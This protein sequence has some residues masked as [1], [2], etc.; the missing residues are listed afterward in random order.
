MMESEGHVSETAIGVVGHQWNWE[1]SYGRPVRGGFPSGLPGTCRLGV[2]K[3]DLV[4]FSYISHIK[5]LRELEEGDFRLIEVDRRLVLPLSKTLLSVTS[6]DVVHSWSVPSLGVK[7][8]AVPGKSVVVGLNPK[9]CGVS[10]G[11]CAEICGVNHSYMPISVEVLTEEF[12]AKWLSQTSNFLFSGGGNEFDRV[13]WAE[14]DNEYEMLLFSV[15]FIS[16]FMQIYIDVLACYQDP[17]AFVNIVEIAA[18]MPYRGT[19]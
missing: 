3:E 5:K 19:G 4:E 9:R 2:G 7:V 11:S 10:Y 14:D 15:L 8:E 17:M 6:A 16:V 1:Y 13:V 12:F 18:E